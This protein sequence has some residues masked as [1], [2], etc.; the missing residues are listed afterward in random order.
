M[1]ASHPGRNMVSVKFSLAADVNLFTDIKTIR[2]LIALGPFNDATR[3][4]DLT[5]EVMHKY[6]QFEASRSH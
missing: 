1:Q 6:F 2:S 3:Y 5:D 4:E